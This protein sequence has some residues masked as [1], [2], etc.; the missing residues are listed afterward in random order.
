M[1]VKML[2][3]TIAIVKCKNLDK[4]GCFFLK[5]KKKKTHVTMKLE[6]GSGQNVVSSVVN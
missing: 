4:R 6:K 3:A 2:L 1:S 5:K